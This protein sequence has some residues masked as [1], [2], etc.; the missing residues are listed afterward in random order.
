[1]DDDNLINALRTEQWL[2]RP[3]FS[4]ALHERLQAAIRRE[5]R[6]RRRTLASCLAAGLAAVGIL[7]ACGAFDREDG[8]LTPSRGPEQLSSGQASVL[9]GVEILLQRSDRAAIALGKRVP[10]PQVSLKTPWQA[11]GS[12]SVGDTIIKRFPFGGSKTTRDS[13]A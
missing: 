9:A 12:E 5:A 4:T 6:R 2:A 1:M 10:W 13:E 8:S 3:Q 11:L 7:A